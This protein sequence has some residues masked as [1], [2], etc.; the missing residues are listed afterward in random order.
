LSAQS[1]KE[2]FALGRILLDVSVDE[3][4]SRANTVNPAN[5]EKKNAFNSSSESE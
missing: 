3:K 4:C 1:V 5:I 2:V